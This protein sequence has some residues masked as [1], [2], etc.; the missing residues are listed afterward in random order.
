MRLFVVWESPQLE[1]RAKE[2]FQ[3]LCAV[4][5]DSNKYTYKNAYTLFLYAQHIHVAYTHH[6]LS[7]TQNKIVSAEKWIEI[8]HCRNLNFQFSLFNVRRLIMHTYENIRYKCMKWNTCMRLLRFLV[9]LTFL[10]LRNK[11]LY[12]VIIHTAMIL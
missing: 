8:L 9:L 10:A 2:N 5:Y 4:D 3:C 12:M 6:I 1:L 7:H 11:M